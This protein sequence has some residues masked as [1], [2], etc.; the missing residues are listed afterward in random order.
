MESH[1]HH[2]IGQRYT[3]GQE[4]LNS[5]RQLIRSNARDFVQQTGFAKELHLQ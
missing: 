1:M 3:F 4:I 5:E 2:P